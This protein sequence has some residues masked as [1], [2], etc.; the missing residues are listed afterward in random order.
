MSRLEPLVGRLRT[1]YG[2]LPSPPRDPFA[3]FVWE[4]LSMQTTPGR[5]DA[6]FSGLKR[7]RALTPDALSRLTQKKIGEA[8]APAGPYQEQRVRALRAGVDLFRRA[9]RLSTVI[10]GPLPAA[11]RALRS[12]PRLGGNYAHRI[13]LFSADRC[14]L[15]EDPV[16]HRVG[17]RLDFGSASDEGRKSA[18]IVQR[19]L[20][21]EL[22][23]DP[24]AFRHAYLYLSHHGIATC[25]ERDPHCQ[26][27]PLLAD[28]PEGSK[29]AL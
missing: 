12:F 15:P 27:C 22:P 28:C 18:R 16:V 29:R 20:V 19:A 17:R 10:A 26:V 23:S 2:L 24:A 25:L 6:A 21:A 11:R 13:L 7:I 5:R 1:F 9:P 4:V 3:L 14:L 8:V